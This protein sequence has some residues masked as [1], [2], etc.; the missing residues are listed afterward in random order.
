MSLEC[1]NERQIGWTHVPESTL[2]VARGRDELLLARRPGD[3]TNG[4]VV[5]LVANECVEAG[6]CIPVRVQDGNLKW[7]RM[8]DWVS[9]IMKG[10]TDCLPCHPH[11]PERGIGGIRFGCRTWPSR[12]VAA[13]QRDCV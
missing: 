3:I 8:M 13:G 9:G 6:P 4:I 10:C 2:A 1:P 11:R 7:G 5:A 12:L